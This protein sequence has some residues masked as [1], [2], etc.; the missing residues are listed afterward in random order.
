MNYSDQ[1]FGSVLRLLREQFPLAARIQLIRESGLSPNHS[2]PD[3]LKQDITEFFD[4]VRH[5]TIEDSCSETGLEHIKNSFKKFLTSPRCWNALFSF[6]ELCAEKTGRFSFRADKSTPNILHE[7]R[8]CAHS[9]G[10]LV[11][12]FIPYE[13]YLRQGGLDADMTGRIRHDSIEDF[14]ESYRSL[15]TRMEK[16]IHALDLPAD[17]THHKLFQANLG[18]SNADIMSRKDAKRTVT[19]KIMRRF[20]KIVKIERYGGDSGVYFRKLLDH[21]MALFGKYA[22]RTE[23]V[24]TRHGVPRFSAKSN[25]TYARETREIYG[26]E[27]HDDIAC[28]RWPAFADAIRSA[29]DMLGVNLLILEGTNKYKSNKALRPEQAHPFRLERYLPNALIP[30]QDLPAVFHPVSIHLHMLEREVSDD[31]RMRVIIDNLIAPPIANAVNQYELLPIPGVADNDNPPAGSSPMLA[32]GS[33]TAG[34]H[35]RAAR[36]PM[37]L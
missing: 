31:P 37:M 34:L 17:E 10:L 12:G 9:L 6:E 25:R 22:D 2:I 19:G 1:L 4:S 14:G 33:G 28:E 11:R 36:A 7:I 29:D 16:H 23:N 30:Y 21:P 32:T 27:A 3:D 15:Y 35:G 18:A 13:D 24:A 20:D 5:M 8:N 26:L